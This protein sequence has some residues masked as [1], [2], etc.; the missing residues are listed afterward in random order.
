MRLLVSFKINEIQGFL[1]FQ[2]HGELVLVSRIKNKEVL[3]LLTLK[4]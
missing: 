4:S 1:T 3:V 2:S